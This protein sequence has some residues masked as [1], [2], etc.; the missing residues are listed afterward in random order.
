MALRLTID[1]R[2]RRGGGRGKVSDSDCRNQQFS[3][4]QDVEV[5]QKMKCPKSK[6]FSDRHLHILRPQT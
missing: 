4:F 3:T 2:H 5:P 1:C 6:E